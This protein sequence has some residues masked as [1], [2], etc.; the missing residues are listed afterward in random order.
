MGAHAGT[1]A[2]RSE[3][4]HEVPRSRTT[5]PLQPRLAGAGAR[6]RREVDWCNDGEARLWRRTPVLEKPNDTRAAS[7]PHLE[8]KKANIELGRV[9]QFELPER[10]AS[11]EP[12]DGRGKRPRS[13]RAF[14][15][16]S[17]TPQSGRNQ[18][19]NWAY[20]EFGRC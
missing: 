4:R 18:I 3:V 10:C 17:G 8:R 2:L 16:K 15:S 14:G 1:G 9:V 6:S 13:T 7:R 12:W 19:L 5:A 20:F 11:E